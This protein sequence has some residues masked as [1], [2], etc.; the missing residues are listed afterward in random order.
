MQLQEDLGFAGFR[1][2]M[3]IQYEFLKGWAACNVQIIFLI[4]HL[5]YMK[6]V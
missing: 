4:M 5:E 3:F 1:F 6:Y 2:G